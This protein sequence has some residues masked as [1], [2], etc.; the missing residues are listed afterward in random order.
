MQRTVLSTIIAGLL[1]GLSSAAIASSH[2][3]APLIT[4]T[5]KVDGT[6]FYM[7]RSYEAGREGYVTFIANYV[8]LQDAY[9]GPNYFALD[10]NAVYAINIDNNGD[11]IADLSFEFRATNAI[12]NLT[13]PVNGVDVKVPLSNIGQFGT[14]PT[15]GDAGK[16]VIETYTVTLAREGK[17]I[18]GIGDGGRNLRKPFD[19]IGQKSIPN[20]A[21]YADSHIQT[22]R[23]RTCASDARVFVGQRKDGFAVALGKIF[24]L[25]N[26]NPVG[27]VDGNPNELA[28]KNV[29]SFA[30][31]IPI[32]CL[33][34]GGSPI[35]GA[36]TTARKTTNGVTTQLSRLGAP[37]VN[38]VVI[39]L[40]DK[41]KFNASQ[42][43]DDGQF[44]TYV[45]NPTLPELLQ[46]LF[47]V[48]QAPNLFPRTDLIAAFLTGLDGL[49]KPANVVPSEML[50]LNTSIA[51]K[52]AANQSNLGALT[53]D[54]A[55]FPN[56]RRPGDDVVDIELRVAMGVLLSTAD[57]PSGQL[58]YTDG[59]TVKATDFRNTFPYL[60]TP[61]PGA[62]F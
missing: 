10:P 54:T 20:Y 37:L 35:I 27:P 57:A 55:G 30:I 40:G 12:Q 18:P 3:E 34:T 29:T 28:D 5:P 62:T 13:V 61:I 53:G 7:F 4:E 22:V 26:L 15:A 44:A 25:V 14:T 21:A 51:P 52:V 43:K 50:R 11:A 17:Q 31:E 32:A 58:P 42:P 56:G 19:N 47:P 60:N 2:R 48:V 45:T 38:E 33:T 9:G 24:D 1:L 39:G 59:A 49:N 41:D 8:P 6:D 16:N 23:F 46:I 36:W